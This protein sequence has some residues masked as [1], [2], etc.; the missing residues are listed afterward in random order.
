MTHFFQGYYY[1]GM[2]LIWWILWGCIWIWIFG[3]LYYNPGQ[4]WRKDSPMD[5]LKRRLAS[6]EITED[7]YRE[8]KKIL[9]N[10]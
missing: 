6:G 2:H 5:I 4:R 3:M 9:E 7:E 10:E 1:A 8:R